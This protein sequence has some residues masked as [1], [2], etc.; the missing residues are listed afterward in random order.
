M[1]DNSRLHYKRLEIKRKNKTATTKLAGTQQV[2][3]GK[4]IP[5]EI[6]HPCIKFACCLSKVKQQS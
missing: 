6:L 3:K 5:F 2:I 1:C 4:N